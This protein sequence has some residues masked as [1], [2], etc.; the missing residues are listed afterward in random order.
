MPDVR[1]NGSGSVE[2]G[3]AGN[4]AVAFLE[5]A[6]R[7]SL[8]LETGSLDSGRGLGIS[9]R[10]DRAFPANKDVRGVRLLLRDRND[11]ESPRPCERFESSHG[12]KSAITEVCAPAQEVKK[13]GRQRDTFHAAPRS[14]DF[15]KPL[16]RRLVGALRQADEERLLR[17]QT[18]PPSRGRR[19]AA[20]LR[21]DRSAR[22]SR[23]SRRPLRGETRRPMA[24]RSHGRPRR[25]PG[26][27]RRRRPD[28]RRP[29]G[30]PSPRTL[31][32]AAWR[33]SPCAAAAPAPGRPRA[34]AP[35]RQRLRISPPRCPNDRASRHPVFP[36]T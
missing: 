18:R 3:E 10:D 27:E 22:A 1:W 5:L 20:A 31:H 15:A 36:L 25:R 26:P 23:Q 6:H 34:E 13:T 12:K 8:H 16:D 2:N 17:D 19:E 9:G 30:V 32:A 24:P 21:S 11:V 35:A 33:R 28:A 7:D 14:E 4:A 29:P